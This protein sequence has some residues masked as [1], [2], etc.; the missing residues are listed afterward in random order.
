MNS[1]HL[2]WF[3]LIAAVLFVIYFLTARNSGKKPT[4]L[5]LRGGEKK[6]EEPGALV[7]V[8]KAGS[9]SGVIDDLQ[10]PKKTIGKTNSYSE[11]H[12]QWLAP[13]ALAVPE[14]K[15]PT[16]PPPKERSLNVFFMYN[17]H[18][19]D[20]FQVLDLAAGSTIPMVTQVYQERLKTAEP[21]THLFLEA[22]Y[23]AILDAYVGRRL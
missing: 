23:K 8:P 14:V 9:V 2:F 12:G 3:N 18:D 1:Q 16:K 20:A 13:E 6:T 10:V 22:A 7:A 4:Q 17:G 15:A 5:N 21:S 11:K 19:W